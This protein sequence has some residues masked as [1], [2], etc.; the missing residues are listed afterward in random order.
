MSDT[1]PPRTP[2][3]WAQLLGE[4]IIHHAPFTADIA[5]KAKRRATEDF[6]EGLESHSAKF[7]G[8]IMQMIL[9]NCDPPEPIAALLREVIEPKAQFSAF[10]EQMFVF[11]I[12]SSIISTSLQPFLQEVTNTLSTAAVAAGISRPIDPAQLVTMGV[13]GL[14]TTSTPLNAISSDI[15]EEAAKSG[16]GQTELAAMIAAAG[17]PPSPQDLFEM[18]RRSIIDIDGLKEGL[19]QGDTK[20]S[21]IANFVQL[22]YTTPTPIDMVRAAVQN[23]LTYADANALAITLGLEPPGYVGGNPDW[24]QLLFDIAGR[25]PGPEEWGRAANRGIVGWSGSGADEVTF[26]Q[27]I[28]ESDIKTKYTAALQ[29]L[30]AHYPT[31]GEA[32]ELYQAGAI[33]KDQLTAY[34]QG[35]GL[36]ATLVAA[37]E[38]QATTQEIAQDRA[39]AKGDVL[40]SLFDGVISQDQAVTLLGDVGYFGNTATYLVDITLMRREIRA[41]T[42]AVNKVGS[43]YIGYKMTLAD[44]Q[45]SLNAL[46]ISDAEATDLIGIWQTERKPETRLP[47]VSELAKAV[48]YSG[49]PFATAVSKAELLGYTPYDATL[50]IAAGAEQPPTGNVWPADT[51]TGVDV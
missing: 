34:L 4:V 30:A 14:D 28:A 39:L 2:S 29:S 6:L 46:G 50:V 49:L 48:Q 40:T 38:F 5:E 7:T 35:N 11:G 18:F 12:A 42:R 33:T 8:P 27:A 16:V 1:P 37:Y 31:A 45:S 9:D 23:Q 25:P 17:S 15:Y 43:L 32:R 3:K 51:D 47:S 13:R 44:A 22:A 41:V 19:Q 20:D 24:F 21:W 10:V 26:Q 36:D